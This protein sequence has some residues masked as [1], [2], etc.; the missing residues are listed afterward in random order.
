MCKI[1]KMFVAI[2]CYIG[3]NAM[4]IWNLYG[5]IGHKPN[6]TETISGSYGSKFGS[7]QKQNKIF[8]SYGSSPI[9]QDGGST[10][11]SAS[12]SWIRPTECTG[13][14][15]PISPYRFQSSDEVEMR[16]LIVM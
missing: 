16:R 12:L 11:V 3:D 1:K 6:Q 5:K 2:Y 7:K 9:N 10:T 8:K 4:V 15:A 13:S 14:V